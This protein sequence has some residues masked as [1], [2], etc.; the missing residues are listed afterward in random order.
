M[1]MWNVNPR[2]MCTQ[3]LLGEHLEMHMFVGTI[4]KGTKL[5]GYIDKG[6][7]E[8]ENISRR[9]DIIVREMLRREMNHNTP[10]E[11]TSNMLGGK[12][13]KAENEII[14]ISRCEKCKKLME[15]KE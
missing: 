6:L 8:I 15:I 4:K 5:N 3:H 2:K 14:L 9:H 12:V 11:D 10:I 13:N 1:R 7:V